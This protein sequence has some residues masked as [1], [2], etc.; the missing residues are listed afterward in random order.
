MKRAYI[1]SRVSCDDSKCIDSTVA[2]A[3]FI[4]DKCKMIPV[5]S[6]LYSLIFNDLNDKFQKEIG[7][8]I[9]LGNILNSDEVWVFGETLTDTMQDE[10]TKSK[11]LN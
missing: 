9:R 1:C 10:L 8:S 7:M 3:K 4:Y 5:M 6:H 11:G 2:Y